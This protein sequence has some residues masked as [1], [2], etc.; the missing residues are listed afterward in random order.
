MWR[1]SNGVCVLVFGVCVG[2]GECWCW[3]YMLVLGVLDLRCVL[4]LRGLAH[5]VLDIGSV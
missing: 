2:L 1:V 5:M 4:K 3:K